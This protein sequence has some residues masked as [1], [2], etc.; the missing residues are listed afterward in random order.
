VFCLY[1]TSNLRSG[2]NLHNGTLYEDPGMVKVTIFSAPRPMISSNG[3]DFTWA[4]QKL[5]LRSWLALSDKVDVVLIGK[6]PSIV[7]LKDEF[8]SRVMIEP[9]IDFT[10]ELLL[11]YSF[12]IPNFISGCFMIA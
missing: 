12:E 4:R 6:H 3:S 10:Y 2:K 8:T 9:A 11:P 5:A 7:K 1:S